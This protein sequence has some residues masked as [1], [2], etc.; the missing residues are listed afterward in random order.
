MLIALGLATILSLTV[1]LL[2]DRISAV[3]GLILIPTVF[4]ILGGFGPEL[5][6]M[7][8]AGVK[9]VASTAATFVFA[10]LYFG[11]VT[12]AGLLR[13]VIRAIVRRVG[14]CPLRIAVGTAVLCVLVHLDGAA[15]VCFLVTVNAMMPLYDKLG[16]DR[17][18]LACIC[19]LGAGI[20]ILPWVAPVLRSSAVLHMTPM[21]IFRPLIVPAVVGVLYLLAVAAYLGA[22]ERRRVAAGAVGTA[23]EAGECGHAEAVAD[24]DGQLARLFWFNAVV[25]LVI[26]A[27]IIWGVYQPMVV[28]MAGT[29]IVLIVNYPRP[30]D[31]MERL[32]AHAKAALMMAAI[33]LA[34][35]VFAGVLHETGMLK[36]IA[37]GAAHAF[38]Q[39]SGRFIPLIIALLSAPMSVLFDPDSYYFGVLPILSQ[40]YASLGG[41][42]VEVARAS[43]MGLHTVGATLSPNTPVTFLLIGMTG[44]T[45]GQHQRYLWKYALG[46]SFA[47]TAAALLCGAIGI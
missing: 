4:A 17:R 32:N 14:A 6:K 46:G 16:M 44:I 11:V 29:A 26:L 20:N 7:Y 39:G 38:P 31:Q 23:G 1:L 30:R 25:T 13:P 12:D 9:T 2:M 37:E 41:E 28:F 47:M 15:A 5:G 33:L 3:A 35:G 21:E 40:M 45:L 8:V 42:P 34:S 43:L 36:A 24:D 27:V 19:G 18:V 10:I 22:K